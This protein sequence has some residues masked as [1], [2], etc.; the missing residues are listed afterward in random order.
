MNQVK[1][2]L[3]WILRIL[4]AGLFIFSGISKTDPIWA[5]DK[6]LV[7][8]GIANWCIAP[9]ITRLIIALELTIAIALM[10]NHY[11]KRLVIPLTIFLLI[12]FILQ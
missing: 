12:A 8:L 6:Q 3:P 2:Y 10:Q 5:F 1:L 7:D 9:F 11:I 4:L